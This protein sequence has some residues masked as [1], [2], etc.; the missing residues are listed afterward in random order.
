MSRNRSIDK[1]LIAYSALLS[2]NCLNYTGLICLALVCYITLFLH[3]CIHILLAYKACSHL[4]KSLCTHSHTICNATAAY[5][6]AACELDPPQAKLDW[7]KISWFN[8]IKEFNLLKDCHTDIWETPWAEPVIREAMKQRLCIKW[9]EE[10]IIQ[11]N[12]EV[13][14]LHTHIYDKKEWYTSILHKIDEASDPIYFSVEEYCTRWQHVNEY[15]L[16]QILHIFNL[17]RF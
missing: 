13:C 17:L 15:L 7:T 3:L 2:N 1:P 10:E 12:V 16:E 6:K 5:N 11:C 9:A 14:Q 4:S 8:Y